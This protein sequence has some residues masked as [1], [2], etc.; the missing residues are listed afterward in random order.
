VVVSST[1][2]LV[3]KSE[4]LPLRPF[5]RQS[6]HEVPLA[7]CMAE[8][9]AYSRPMWTNQR[10]LQHALRM[11]ILAIA[12]VLSPAR[13]AA[14]EYSAADTPVL[15]LSSAGAKPLPVKPSPVRERLRTSR[16][17][18]IAETEVRAPSRLDA[19]NDAVRE[20]LCNIAFRRFLVNCSWL[21]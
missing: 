4:N 8:A 5:G 1:I 15:L 7:P 13:T 21:N 11:L 2:A 3:S 16:V 6:E 9:R 12:L 17:A 19:P 10:W 14:C 20:R 18:A